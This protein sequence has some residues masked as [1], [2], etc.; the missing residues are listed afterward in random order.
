MRSG[1][2]Y[3]RLL[4]K[5]TAPIG[6]ANFYKGYGLVEVP[7]QQAFKSLAVTGLVASHLISHFATLVTSGGKALIYKAFLA[8]SIQDT[9]PKVNGNP[10]EPVSQ[11]HT[12]GQKEWHRHRI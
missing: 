4:Y 8:L 3:I 11:E 7:L 6:A 1:P 9:L 10:C 2:V 5:K 12:G